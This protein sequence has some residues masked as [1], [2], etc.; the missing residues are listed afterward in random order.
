MKKTCILSLIVISLLVVSLSSS[1]IQRFTVKGKIIDAQTC[2][3]IP[4][5]KIIMHH[6]ENGITDELFTKEDGE[7]IKHFTLIGNVT[8]HAEKSGYMPYDGR[9]YARLGDNELLIA[10]LRENKPITA[11]CSEIENSPLGRYLKSMITEIPEIPEEKG[12]GERYESAK[13]SIAIQDYDSAIKTLLEEEKAVPNNFAISFYLGL[14]YYETQKYD[15]AIARWSKAYETSPSKI[16][17]L[18]NLC[19]A[20]E[21]KGD[22]AKAADYIQKYAD[23]FSKLD[24]AKPAEKKQAYFDA[25][26]Y[27]YNA[28]VPEKYFEAFKKVVEFDPTNGDA[29]YYIGMYYFSVQKNKECVDAMEKAIASPIITE[30]N[31]QTAIAI[32]DAA[33]SV[34]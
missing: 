15:E 6:I 26:V 5:V 22:R 34:M 20:W 8:V 21:K 25:G 1:A 32:R 7:Y 3:R 29:W 14:C 31:K 11:V 9:V 13:A 33:K 16:I 24:T 28:S 19:K 23:E 4:D 17:I 30:D 12:L 27:W 10:M 18:K 2:E